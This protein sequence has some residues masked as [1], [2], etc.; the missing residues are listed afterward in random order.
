M[1]FN[2]VLSEGLGD[3][4]WFIGSSWSC[5]QEAH[6]S[7]EGGQMYDSKSQERH[8]SREYKEPL[9]L[10]WEGGQKCLRDREKKEEQ[11]MVGEREKKQPYDQVGVNHLVWWSKRLDFS[12]DRAR[13]ALL[14]KAGRCP[15]FSVKT[16]LFVFLKVRE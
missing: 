15:Q 6:W 7:W 9:E 10:I 11:Q 14:E 4:V 3:P 5:L 1:L 16:C 8:G 13:R 2:H 12:S